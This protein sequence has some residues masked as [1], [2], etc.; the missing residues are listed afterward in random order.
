MNTL[1]SARLQQLL[2][3][4]QLEAVLDILLAPDATVQEEIQEKA[5][6][7]SGRLEKLRDEIH[8]G[9][10]TF[11]QSNLEEN[12]IRE[13]LLELIKTISR[14]ETGSKNSLKK[15]NWMVPALLYGLMAI[16]LLWCLFQPVNTFRIEADLLVERVGFRYLGGPTDFAQGNLHQVLWQNYSEARFDGASIRLD[17]TLNGIWEKKLALVSPLRIQSNPD[18]SGTGIQIGPVRLEKLLLTPGAQVTLSRPEEDESLLR[19]TVQQTTALKGECTYN[20]SLLVQ[21]EQVA[22]EGIPGDTAFIYPIQLQIEAPAGMARE[23]TI[24]GFPGSSTL[25]LALAEP[26]SMESKNLS[27]TDL[28]FYQPVENMAFPTLLSGEIRFVEVDQSTARTLSISE[29]EAL[30]ISVPEKLVLE[31]L[32]IRPEGISLRLSGMVSR[33]ETGKYRDLRNPL[34]LEW[35]WHNHRTLLLALGI[36]FLGLSLFLPPKVRDR[37]FELLKIVNG[38]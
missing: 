18:I 1:N 2:A 22:I 21:A 12:R 16:A 36:A 5:T 32:T 17:R 30:D 7:L 20:G 10:R 24:T 6:A 8:N 25:D 31:H 14:P 33:L 38:Y 4:N 9:T 29:G 28:S 37:I 15:N 27:V 19:L 3:D 23:I 26:L 34:R 35:L 11:E 13:A